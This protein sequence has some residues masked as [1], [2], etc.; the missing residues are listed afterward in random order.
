[1]PRRHGDDVDW[2]VEMSEWLERREHRRKWIVLGVCVAVPLLLMGTFVGLFYLKIP[3]IGS[4][5][6]RIFPQRTTP[7]PRP[8]Q[9]RMHEI[10]VDSFVGS[11]VDIRFNQLDP[12]GLVM[13]ATHVFREQKPENAPGFLVQ[14]EDNLRGKI[15]SYRLR[16]LGT[17]DVYDFTDVPVKKVDP[18]AGWRIEDEVG[19]KA[20]RDQLGAKMKIQFAMPIVGRN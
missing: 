9:E 10:Q 2:Y 8:G 15:R 20:V 19:W 14:T 11:N 1:M 17:G 18:T 5:F 4:L 6:H 12:N 16:N 13:T 7:L 3:G